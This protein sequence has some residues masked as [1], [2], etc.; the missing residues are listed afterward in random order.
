MQHSRSLEQHSQGNDA[1]GLEICLGISALPYE[2][3]DTR[4]GCGYIPGSARAL[5]RALGSPACSWGGGGLVTAVARPKWLSS[6]SCAADGV[7]PPVLLHNVL[8]VTAEHAGR[9]SCSDDIEAQRMMVRCACT[10]QLTANVL[11]AHQPGEGH[12]L[13]PR[14]IGC[15]CSLHRT[16]YQRVMRPRGRRLGRSGPGQRDW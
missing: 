9:R 4:G 12:R 13:G 1:P 14:R 7:L 10:C 15:G 6:R 11:D 2:T 5:S 8:G 16:R 3:D